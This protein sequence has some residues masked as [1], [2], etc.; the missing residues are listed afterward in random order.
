MGSSNLFGQ[1]FEVYHQFISTYGSGWEKITVGADGNL[2]GTG[3]GGEFGR[4]QIFRLVPDGSG[5]FDYELLY[6]FHGPEGTWPAGLV[7]GPDGR[8]YGTTF[9]GGEFGGGTVYAFDLAS[10]FVLFHSFPL[11]SFYG[12]WLPTRLVAASDGN[13]YG[14]TNYGGVHG[15]G[16]IYRITPTGDYTDLHD[17]AGLDGQRPYY[18]LIQASDGY[19]YGVCTFGG[20]HLPGAPTGFGLYGG[21][22]LFRSDL[23]GNVT[24]LLSFP[25]DNNYPWGDLVEAPDG[26][27]YGTMFGGGSSGTGMAYRSDKSG[28]LTVLHNF[29]ST[30]GEGSGPS[31]GLI[32]STG[33]VFYGITNVG[34]SSD[35]GTVYQMTSDGTVTTLVS[36]PGPYPTGVGFPGYGLTLLPDGSLVGI[37]ATGGVNSVGVVF[38]VPPSGGSFDVI[39][40]FGGPVGV[41]NPASQLVQTADGTLWGTAGGGAAGLGTVYRLSGDPMVVHEFSGADGASPGNL[42]ATPDG[43]LY[44]VTASQGSG[45]SGTIFKLDADGTFTTLHAFSGLDGAEPGGGLMQASDGNFYGTTAF[46]GVNGGGTL[47][48]ITSSGVHAKLHDFQ[49]NAVPEEPRGRII[50]ASDGMLYFTTFSTFGSLYQSDLAG[51]LTDLH[52]WNSGDAT[53]PPDG[54]IQADDGNLYGTTRYYG[55]GPGGGLFRFTLPSTFTDLFY[56]SGYGRPLGTVVQGGDGRLYGTATGEGVGGPGGVWVSDLSGANFTWIRTLNGWDGDT[57]V[58]TLTRAADGMLYGATRGGGAGGLGLVFRLDL[59]NSPPSIVDLS[60]SSGLAS[61][62]VPVTVHGDHFRPSISGTL[63]PSPFALQ[64]LFDAHTHFG[65]SPPLSPGSLNDV[66]VTNTDGQSA[67]LSAAFFADFLDAPSGVL[68][69]DQ[70]EMI[71]RDGITAGCGAGSY[72]PDAATSRAQMSVFLLKGEHGAGYKPP[73]CQGIFQ[74]VTCPSLF[75]DWIEQFA[76]EADHGRVRQR[77]LLSAEPRGARSGSGPVAQGRARARLRPAELSGHLRRRDLPLDLRRLDRATRGRGHH[78]RLRQRQF[79]PRQP[80]HPR[81]DGGVSHEDTRS[82]V[83]SEPAMFPRACGSAFAFLFSAATVFGQAYEI[84]Q[85]FLY[86]GGT[87]RAPMVAASDGSFYGVDDFGGDFSVGAI[88]RLTPDG[89]G[90]FTSQVLWSFHGP[91]GAYPRALMQAADSKFYGIA[92][93]AGQLLSGTAFVFDATSGSLVRLHNFE[94]IDSSAYTSPSGLLQAADGQLYGVIF[95][96]GAQNLGTFYRLS[97]SGD[98]SVLH[99]F[100]GPEGAGPFGALMQ[101]SDGYLYGTTTSGGDTSGGAIFRADLS[102]NVDQIH[103]FTAAEATYPNGALVEGLD[104]NLYGT[105]FTGGSGGGGTVFRS[106]KAGNVAVLF[107]FPSPD[108]GANPN[109]GLTRAADGSFYGTTE[110]GGPGGS[111][112]VFHI[113]TDGDLTTVASLPIGNP[114]EIAHPVAGVTLASDGS[115]WGTAADGG[116]DNAGGVFRIPLPDT[117][118]A[119]LFECGSGDVALF[120]TRALTETSDGTLWGVAGGTGPFGTVFRLSGASRPELVHTFQG[121]LDGDLSKDLRAGTD[122]NLYGTTTNGGPDGLGTVFRI[123]GAS[124]AKTTLHGFAGSDGRNPEAGLIQGTDGNFYGTTYAGG[125]SDV[126]TLFRMD[127]KGNLTTLVRPRSHRPAIPPGGTTGPGLGRK[128]VHHELRG[129]RPASRHR[130]PQ[131]PLRRPHRS[132]QL[133]SPGRPLRSDRPHPGRRRKLLRSDRF[134]AR[135]ARHDLP[136]RQFRRIHHDSQLRRQRQNEVPA[137]PGERRAPLRNGVVRGRPLERLDLSPRPLRREL[138]DP[139]RVRQYSARRLHPGLRRHALRKCRERR[140]GQR[141]RGLS[142]RPER[143]AAV[144]RIPLARVGPRG[145]RRHRDDR[146]RSPPSRRHDHPQRFDP[147]RHPHDLQRNSRRLRPDR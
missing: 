127:M 30:P 120:P 100:L 57:P 137:D 24:A 123:D 74:D 25:G 108:G 118:P 76:A 38:R 83:D 130:V 68:F 7:Q 87:P 110:Y 15:V 90:G 27:L 63:G 86:E 121:G 92:Q 82:A 72:C 96:G 42:Y 107:S 41:A 64:D 144:D 18:A 147:L 65:V 34:G 99:D 141:R 17:F 70:I 146:R 94:P 54:V 40:D 115:L 21:G 48:R 85:Q 36:F 80:D 13:L 47:Y 113:T 79:L 145:G 58:A 4:G 103:A 6:S 119:I 126:G 5:G 133:R 55:N 11:D 101:A 45:G 19:L 1:Q 33:G 67:T 128:P 106:D 28:N 111:G 44:G 60:P 131:R 43:S 105:S 78:R 3:F 97:P 31:G 112:I 117:N 122:G 102:G 62:G 8:F 84:A 89:S 51:N 37:T 134:D 29:P 129:R 93:L 2:Y 61:G 135:V 95:H 114:L 59:A 10:G 98:F 91:D 69:H 73:P 12:A 53:S 75:A 32:R 9:Y 20:S 49:A 39:R 23:S 26:N 81:P 71:F 143:L 22:T 136:N 77:Q 35:S 140:L 138:R 52:D 56:F 50:Q 66:T 46:G 124:L 104:G 116:L 132:P 16:T 125:T 14:A 109:A 88:F 142:A 139:P